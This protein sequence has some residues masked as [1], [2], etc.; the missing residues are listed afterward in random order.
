V[1]SRK[2][3]CP[4]TES[5]ACPPQLSLAASICIAVSTRVYN[6]VACI[7]A[8]HTPLVTAPVDS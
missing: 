7:L 8:T 4:V 1:H 6:V 3:A 2:L 5:I